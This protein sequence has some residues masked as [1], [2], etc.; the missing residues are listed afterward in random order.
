MRRDEF[1]LNF[2][3]PFYGMSLW[4]VMDRGELALPEGA[5]S[6]IGARSAYAR[7]SWMGLRATGSIRP[8]K[9]PPR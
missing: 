6:Y 9:K 1:C 8:R 3:S 7:C 4:E 5:P 2:A